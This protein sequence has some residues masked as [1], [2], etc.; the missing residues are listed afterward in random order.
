MTLTNGQV[1]IPGTCDTLRIVS[2]SGLGGTDVAVT[3]EVD[4][5]QP[6]E[7][8]VLSIQHANGATLESIT[9][10]GTDAAAVGIE[11]EV[12][13]LYPTG[14]TLGV[15]FDFDP[16]YGGQTLAPGTK[17][18]LA[19]FVYSNPE[20]E[21]SAPGQGVR[22]DLRQRGLRHAAARTSSSR[23]GSAPIRRSSTAR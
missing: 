23:A 5:L 1:T 22:A 4:N 6:V 15:V 17:N 19:T 14:G 10:A 3:V 16:P 20:F 21:C 2:A 7:G 11:F 9:T 18:S 12:T 8:Y 13:K